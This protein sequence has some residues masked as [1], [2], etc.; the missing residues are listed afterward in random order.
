V[1]LAGRSIVLHVAYNAGLFWAYHVGDFNQTYPLAR[2]VGP[3]VVA[4]FA[5]LVLNEPL[6]APAAVGVVVIAV[7]IGVLARR[8]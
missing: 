1:A 5:T 7:S 4:A 2:G 6:A 8:A 3:L